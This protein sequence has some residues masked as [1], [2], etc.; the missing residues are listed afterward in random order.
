VISPAGTEG[1]HSERTAL[2][3]TLRVLMPFAGTGVG[4]SVVSSA[5][6]MRHLRKHGG[7]ESIV[8]TPGHG[9]STPIF[10]G[11]G[12]EVIHSEASRLN[13]DTGQL[14]GK[15][16][17][18]PRYA[19]ALQHARRLLNELKPD[20][21][22]LN[23]DRLVLPWG[24][25]ALTTDVPVVWHVR[26]ELPNRMLDGIRLKL[27]QHLIFVAE[28]NRSRFEHAR[29]LPPSTRLYNVVDTERFHP[30]FDVNTDKI[31]AG[32]NPNRVTLTFLG[33]LVERKRAEWVLRAAG[34]L[35]KV[36]PLQVVLIG[37]PLGPRSYVD[38]LHTLAQ[39]VC[40]PGTVLF[41]GQRN[42][43]AELLRASDLVTLPSVLKGEA[44]PRAIIEAMA[45]GL[46]VVATDVAGVS[47]AVEQNET[48]LLVDALDYQAYVSAL[49]NLV[50]DA[51]RRKQ[52]GLKARESAVSRFSGAGMASSLLAIYGQLINQNRSRP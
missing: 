15:I 51:E 4:G 18:L 50:G 34:E 44:F 20:V 13:V 5:E 22:H 49:K 9:P 46:P 11:I 32:L 47:E 27:S 40:E 24:A 38:H 30:T 1:L 3:G 35:Q 17:A 2:A 45:S 36:T 10:E 31:R 6:M 8:L 39:Q 48:G 19:R 12:A 25:A 14:E 21:L 52:M 26:Q 41:L 43:V 37:A 7:V 33:N 28:A 16:K 23:E 29:R 42:D